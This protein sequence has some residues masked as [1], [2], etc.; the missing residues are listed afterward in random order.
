MYI[1]IYVYQDIETSRHQ[2]IT[3]C[4]TTNLVVMPLMDTDDLWMGVV[5][6]G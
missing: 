3:T 5:F 6:I 4:D 1:Y 2:D